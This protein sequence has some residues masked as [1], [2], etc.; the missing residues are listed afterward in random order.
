MDQEDRIFAE[1][2]TL[3][4]AEEIEAAVP[5]EDIS[6]SGSFKPQQPS[7][8]NQPALPSASPVAAGYF[9]TPVQA[10]KGISTTGVDYFSTLLRIHASILPD[11]FG[12]DGDDLE[13]A[14]TAMDGR[15]AY[16]DAYGKGGVKRTVNQHQGVYPVGMVREY[17]NPP[18]GVHFQL[19]LL[20]FYV[21]PGI[22]YFVE[23]QKGGAHG[24]RRVFEHP[25]VWD[26][27]RIVFDYST[28]F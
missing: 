16:Y 11:V 1:G 25:I 17:G 2:E 18:D 12:S 22:R 15:I 26:G 19:R 9:Q 27:H 23:V 7:K 3:F 14:L 8:P 13:V 4:T 24:Q 21:N 6:A 28:R 20:M 5:G 10:L